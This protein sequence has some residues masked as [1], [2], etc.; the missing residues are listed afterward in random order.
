MPDLHHMPE[1]MN[2][3]D[4]WDYEGEAQL[5]LSEREGHV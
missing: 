3:G 4:L 1:T 2:S 5:L